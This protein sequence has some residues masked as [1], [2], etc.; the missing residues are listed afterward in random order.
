MSRVLLKRF[1]L[2][3]VFCRVTRASRVSPQLKAIARSKDDADRVELCAAFEGFGAEAD[4]GLKDAIARAAALDADGGREATSL[5]L[6]TGEVL[7]EYV[8]GG[9]LQRAVQ[10]DPNWP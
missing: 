10:P 1:G 9:G 2:E 4:Q 5:G 3:Q 6:Q 7:A 8:A